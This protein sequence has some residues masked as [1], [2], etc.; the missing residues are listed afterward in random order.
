MLRPGLLTAAVLASLALMTPA[1]AQPLP[2]AEPP[3]PLSQPLAAPD[4]FALVGQANQFELEESQLASSRARDPRVRVAATLMT[5]DHADM[6]RTLASATTQAGLPHTPPPGL[7]VGQRQAL[8]RLRASS[9]VAFDRRYVD[10]QVDGQ[11]KL[12]QTLIASQS[13]ADPGPARQAIA[14][15][16]PVAARRLAFFRRLKSEIE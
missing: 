5:R 16:R 8:M 6:K 4:V 9:G 10:Q 11:R 13:A 15:I 2:P 3:G 7:D 12:L 1:T 14:R